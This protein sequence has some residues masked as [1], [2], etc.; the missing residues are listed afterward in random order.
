MPHRWRTADRNSPAT[1]RRQAEYRSP[2]H[3]ALRKKY[4]PLVDSGQAQC[5]E[6]ICLHRTRAIPARAQW[7]LAHTPD[8]RGYL[9]PSHPK[10]NLASAAK[11][12]NR[13]QKA[14]R[15]RRAQTRRW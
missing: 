2:V 5:C 8:R 14:R 7:H 4:Q 15:I 10:C 11:A 1:K 9:G 3:K 6:I 12:G 13:A